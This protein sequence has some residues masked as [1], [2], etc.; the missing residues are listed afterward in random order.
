MLVYD[1]IRERIEKDKNF[2]GVICGP[3]GSGKSETA[4]RI[5]IDLDPHF[6]VTKQVVFKASQL[7]K[8]LNSGLRKGSVVVWDEAGVGVPAR[9]WHS[10]S[11]KMISY[12]C[13]T[14][15]NDNLIV[16]FTTPALRYIDSNVRILF[17]AYMEALSIDYFKKTCKV[18]FKY[19]QYNSEIDKLYKKY[20]TILH[21]G[22]RTRVMSFEFK[23][24]PEDVS[25]IYKKTR[26]KYTTDLKK[27]AEDAIT[28]AEN[29]YKAM[30]QEDIV[31]C[32]MQKREYFFQTRGGREYIPLWKVKDYFDIGWFHAKIIKGV[33]E[34]KNDKA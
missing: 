26:A 34:S 20:L 18:K 15:R 7:M 19:L 22:E 8:L 30:S 31:E 21:N 13:Q 29:P 5:A 10:V 32:V 27:Q 1:Y 25:R 3:T 9:E 12:I 16:L 2:L 14:F 24:P 17:H 11:N 23:K 33:A 4:L 6:D 28:M